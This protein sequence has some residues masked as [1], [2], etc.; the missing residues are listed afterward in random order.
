MARGF[1]TAPFARHEVVLGSRDSDRAWKVVRSTG[2]AAMSP[3]E[4]AAGAEVPHPGRTSPPAQT[5]LRPAQR[6]S[7]VTST[8]CQRAKRLP[9]MEANAAAAEPPPRV[10]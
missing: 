7:P 10:G 2:A 5:E 8:R 3:A 4:A 9:V 6:T 1:A